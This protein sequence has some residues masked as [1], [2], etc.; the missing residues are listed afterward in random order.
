MLGDFARSG[1]RPC[2]FGRASLISPPT[3]WAMASSLKQNTVL[4]VFTGPP[5][6]SVVCPTPILAEVDE[7]YNPEWSFFLDNHASCV[8]G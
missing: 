3:S 2:S 5:S 8:K 6:G 1:G 4:W 7:N